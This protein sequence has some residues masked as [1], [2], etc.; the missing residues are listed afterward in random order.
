MTTLVSRSPTAT[1]DPTALESL[2]KDVV[3]HLRKR[4]QALAEEISSYPTP[5]TRCDAQFNHLYE[6]QARL[7]RDL[8]RIAD[9]ERAGRAHY[10]ETIA[11][12][13]DSAP[14]SDETA[15]R[16]FLARVRMEFSALQK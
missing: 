11:R 7:A 16:E 6:Q 10:V 5:I 9:A 13:V 4:K 1:S 14:Y 3:A 8:D 2:W 15:E 12:F